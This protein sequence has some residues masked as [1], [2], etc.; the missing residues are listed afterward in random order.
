MY[1]RHKPDRASIRD[2]NIIPKTWPD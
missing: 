2:F 1:L